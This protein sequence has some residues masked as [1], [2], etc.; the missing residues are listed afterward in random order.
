MGKDKS[1]GNR[2]QQKEHLVRDADGNEFTMTQEEWRGRDKSQSFERVDE[3]EAPAEE[4]AVEEPAAE[5]PAVEESTTT[6]EG[7]VG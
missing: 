4:P 5:E 3:V 1:L 7:A 6:D 2:G